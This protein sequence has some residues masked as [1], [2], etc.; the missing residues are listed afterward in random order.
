VTE[1][2]PIALITGASSGI[3]AALARRFAAG[4]HDVALVARTLPRLQ[5]LADELARTYGIAAH[6]LRADLADPAAPGALTDELSQHGLVVEILVNNAG[7]G[8]WGPFAEADLQRELDM[9]QVNVVALTHLTRL[10]LPGMIAR[11][12][13]KILNVASTAAVAPGPLMAVYY[14][15]KAYV[16][17]F[18]LAIANELEGSGVTVTTLC[19]GPTR[20]AFATVAGM[21]ESILFRSPGVMDADAVARA[22]YEGL[23]RGKTMVVPGLMNKL[24]VLGARLAPRGLL[25]KITRRFQER[26]A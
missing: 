11:G 2:R 21:D 14:A 16:L 18:S 26:R 9:L 3:G 5:E 8:L 6:V 20:T 17:S 13:G 1:S 15:S 4:G 7:F 12:H 23:M 19:P 25:V 24:L 10:L 22:G